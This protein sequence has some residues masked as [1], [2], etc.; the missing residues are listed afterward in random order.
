MFNFFGFLFS[1]LKGI[2]NTC[3]I[4]TQINKQASV[5]HI[6]FAGFFGIFSTSTNKI[7]LDAQ[8]NEYNKKLSTIPNAYDNSQEN[9]N[10]TPTAP[11]L[12]NVHNSHPLSIVTRNYRITAVTEHICTGHCYPQSPVTHI[13]AHQPDIE[14]PMNKYHSFPFSEQPFS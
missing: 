11:Q 9:K 13:T 5:A 2:Y 6:L 10:T 7:F 3:S 12:H 1:I 8:I 14:K 4:H